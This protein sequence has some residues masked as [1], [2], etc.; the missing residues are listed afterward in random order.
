MTTAQDGGR[1]D[2]LAHRPPLPPGYAPGTHLF[3]CITSTITTDDQQD[4][5]ILIYF[6]SALRVSG[7]VF[8]HHQEHITVSTLVLAYATPTSSN[9]SGH[10]QKL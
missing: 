9:I 2:S 4:A 1:V 7:D 3:L 5:T 6:K 10:Y 8:A